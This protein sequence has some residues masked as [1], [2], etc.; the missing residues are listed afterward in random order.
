MLNNFGGRLGLHGHID[1]YVEGIVNASKQAEHMA[2]IGITPEASVNNPVLYDL[3]FETIWADDG[4]NLETIDLDKWFKNYVTRRYGA[5]SDSAYQA[6]EILHDTVYNPNLNMKGQGAPESVVNAR[7]G[8]NIGAASTWGNAV[9]DYDKKKLEKAAGLLLADYDKLKNS[10]GYQ[11]DLA[12]VLEQVLSNTAQE[13]QKKMAAAFR[14][15]DAEAFNTLSDKFLSI[16]D[17]VEKVTG[18]QKEFLV[19]TWI[20]GAKKLAENAD[21]FTKELYELNARSLITTWGSYD[22]AISGG[23]IDYS[24]RQWA[25]L[26]NDY[27]KMRWEKWIA[28]RKKELAGESYTNY[29]A[30][31]WFEMEWAWARDTN[32][33]SG[34]PNGLDLQDLGTDVLANYS[35]TNMP[36]DPAEDDSRDLSLD[37]MTATA[38]SEQ[39]TTGSEGPASA[40]LDQTTGTI[41]HSKWSGDDRANLWIDIS[42][43]ESKTVTGLRM[44]PRSGGG[45]GTITSYRIEISNDGGQTYQEVATGTWSSSDSWKL[46]EFNAI[47]ATNVRLY[48]VES[49]SDSGSAFAS[50]AEIR[51]MGQSAVPVTVDKSE[52]QKAVDS[53]LTDLSGFTE[54]S[55]TNYESALASARKILADDSATQETVD[56]ALAALQDARNHLVKKDD[57][58]KD[59]G[60]TDDGKTDDG[61]ID[62][63]TGDNKKD[64]SINSGKKPADTS[65]SDD[66]GSTDT[67]TIKS[68]SVK[69]G[70]SGNFLPVMLLLSVSGTFILLLKRKRA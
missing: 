70:D 41:W 54:E 68:V 51:I 48:A 10:A 19:G 46:A 21:D 23:L 22:Q 30:Q 34:T 25:G 16:I 26:T 43:G 63:A 40:V 67:T 24:N 42:L 58:P 11:Y 57:T 64:D 36:K 60:K 4:D 2:G 20:N 50:A 17:M 12:N 15:G 39:A 59:D 3:F 61:K 65:T 32:E 28:E 66:R 27:Y 44:L 5:D 53:A 6:M 37:G 9:V 13:Y 62:N 55:Q 33:Y 38:G 29:S 8:L 1:N 52:L 69:T 18:T 45:N 47:Q 35:L 56:N 7:P 31:N 49:V 14:S